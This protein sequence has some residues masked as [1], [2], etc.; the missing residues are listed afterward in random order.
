[1]KATATVV[2]ANYRD[3]RRVGVYNIRVSEI[4]FIHVGVAI[5]A[6]EQM[7]RLRTDPPGRVSSQSFQIN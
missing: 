6:A 4:T 1:M 5:V 3:E 7:Y 2:V